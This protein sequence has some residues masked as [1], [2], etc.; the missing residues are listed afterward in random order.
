MFGRRKVNL[1]SKITVHDLIRVVQGGREKIL[2]NGQARLVYI[3]KAY[4]IRTE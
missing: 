1:K 2:L 3:K 4:G